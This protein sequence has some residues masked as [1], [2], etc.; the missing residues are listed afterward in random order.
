MEL[1]HAAGSLTNPNGEPADSNKCVA[2]VVQRPPSEHAFDLEEDRA[3][4]RAEM[5]RPRVAPPDNV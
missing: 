3:N 4:A 5:M 1:F 2:S